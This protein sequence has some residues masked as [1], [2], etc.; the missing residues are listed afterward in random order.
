MSSDYLG[1]FDVF[2][3]YHCVKPEQMIR[4]IK[5]LN[6]WKKKKIEHGNTF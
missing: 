6:N 4:N 1:Q 2:F 5:Q 3:W